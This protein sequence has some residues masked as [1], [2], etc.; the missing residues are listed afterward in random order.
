MHPSSGSSRTSRSSPPHHRFLNLC[1]RGHRRRRWKPAQRW[2]A[3]LQIKMLCSINECK[4]SYQGGGSRYTCTHARTHMAGRLTPNGFPRGT[5]TPSIIKCFSLHS[6]T[7]S[8]SDTEAAPLT[9]VNNPPCFSQKKEKRVWERGG[10][11]GEGV[12]IVW[13]NRCQSDG[14][15]HRTVQRWRCCGAGKGEEGRARVHGFFKGF[16]R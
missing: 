12:P 14:P 13:I 9:M 15:T 11:E 6:S 2:L 7:R 3:Q 16:F 1:Y 8:G 4:A 10:E 5:S